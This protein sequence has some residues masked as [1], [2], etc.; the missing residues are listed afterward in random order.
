MEYSKEFYF[1]ENVFGLCLFNFRG[2]NLCLTL[3][4]DLESF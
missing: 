2:V 3:L 4:S 1:I